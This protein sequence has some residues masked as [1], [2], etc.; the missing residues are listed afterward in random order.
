MS[1]IK[2]I[3]KSTGKK[4]PAFVSFGNAQQ[5]PLQDNSVDLIVTSPPY[6]SNAI[7]YMRAHKFSL[8]WL[9]TQLENYLKNGEPILVRIM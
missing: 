3:F 1:N 5:L 7:D 9:V 2:S 6:A 4:F 8:V